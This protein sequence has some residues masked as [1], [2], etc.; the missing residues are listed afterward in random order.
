MPFVLR[1]RLLEE[2][3]AGRGE[4]GEG[5]GE[6]DEFGRALFFSLEDTVTQATRTRLV[7]GAPAQSTPLV[8]RAFPEMHTKTNN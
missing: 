2:A 8:A 7:L 6:S 4:G 1:L 3:A 5:L